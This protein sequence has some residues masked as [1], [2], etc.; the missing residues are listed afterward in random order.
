MFRLEQELYLHFASGERRGQRIEGQLRGVRR[1]LGQTAD[2]GNHVLAP[3]FVSFIQ[4]LPHNQFR[5][6]RRAGNGRHAS[7]RLEPGPG[8]LASAGFQGQP[9]HVAAGGIFNFYRGIRIGK[10]SCIA[11]I[12]EMIE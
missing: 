6:R 9:Q 7:F 1:S 11:R 10:L 3:Q 4:R 2:R 8:N 5:Q 12:L